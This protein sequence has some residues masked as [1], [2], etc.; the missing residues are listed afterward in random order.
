M[1][2]S[3]GAWSSARTAAV[4]PMSIVM[5][6]SPSPTTPSSSESQ[7]RLDRIETATARIIER[8]SAGVTSPSRASSL[9]STSSAAADD[10]AVWRLRCVSAAG[11]GGANDRQGRR[12]AG[13]A[14]QFL[15]LV[16]EAHESHGGA[17]HFQ[18]RGVFADPA[19]VN[20]HAD[21]RKAQG[22]PA[23]EDIKLQQPRGTETL[24]RRAISSPR[25]RGMSARIVSRSWSTTESACSS[26]PRRIPGSPCRPMPISISSRP[27]SKFAFPVCGIEHGVSATPMDPR[28]DERVPCRAFAG[29]DVAAEFGSRAGNLEDEEITRDAASLVHPLRRRRGDIVGHR[30][31]AH[32]NSERCAL[33]R[34][35]VEIHDVAGVVAVEQ[36]HAGATVDG[37]H[38]VHDL[39]G[40]RRGED[41]ADGGCIGKTPPNIACKRRLMARTAADDDPTLP[42]RGPSTATTARRVDPASRRTCGWALTMPSIASPTRSAGALMRR[43]VRC[44][45]MAC[46]FCWPCAYR[47]SDGLPRR[48]FRSRAA[49]PH[50]PLPYRRPSAASA[51]GLR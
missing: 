31:G 5:P 29:F 43:F 14:E 26:G 25:D 13:C 32:R 40:T 36:H 9:R 28:I 51:R 7:S 16:I 34:G 45:L 19:V 50:A 6:W 41:V 47:R 37:T 49:R 2:W 46:S 30:D 1:V 33:L 44:S 38:G 10:V 24:T 4:Q 20:D 35:H 12:A 22:E 3:S 17:R 23:V 15:Q 48:S 42:S 27:I 21:L 11:T 18:R 39:L 8:K